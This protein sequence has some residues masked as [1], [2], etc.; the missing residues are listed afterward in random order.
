MPRDVSLSDA[1]AP[2]GG[3]GALAVDAALFEP[4]EDDVDEAAV[5]RQDV[6]THCA[7]ERFHQAVRAEQILDRVVVQKTA[8]VVDVSVAA[9]RVGDAGTSPLGGAPDDLRARCHGHHRGGRSSD[10]RSTPSDQPMHR[11]HTVPRT[12]EV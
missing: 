1:R 9:L 5:S 4:G 11:V 10:G 7:T 2:F 3:D 12:G 6:L 8:T